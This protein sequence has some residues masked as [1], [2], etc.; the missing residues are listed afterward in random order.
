MI[1]AI[2]GWLCPP[3]NPLGVVYLAHWGGS[4]TPLAKWGGCTTS[5]PFGGDFGHPH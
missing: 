2:W 5:K 3:S 1:I 4:A